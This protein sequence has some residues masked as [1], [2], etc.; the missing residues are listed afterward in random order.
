MDGLSLVGCGC[1]ALQLIIK[2]ILLPLRGAKPSY[3]ELCLSDSCSS[4]DSESSDEDDGHVSKKKKALSAHQTKRQDLR[5]RL[6]P[7]MVY[8]RDLVKWYRH[9]EDWILSVPNSIFR[10]QDDAKVLEDI[11]KFEQWKFCT[12]KMETACRW[13]SA[14]MMWES[15][16]VNDRVFGSVIESCPQELTNVCVQVLA[17]AHNKKHSRPP[18]PTEDQKHLLLSL[19][20]VFNPLRVATKILEQAPTHGSADGH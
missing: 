19:L 14:C 3:K 12:L 13:N 2:H 5:A 1:H 9:H 6:L 18:P 20:A 15:I 10:V 4:T 7:T 17:H 8:A 11:A 16:L